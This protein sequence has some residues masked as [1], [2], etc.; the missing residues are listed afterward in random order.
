MQ[1]IC[2]KDGNE[3]AGNYNGLFNVYGSV[4]RNNILVLVYNYV[5]EYT[6]LLDK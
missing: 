3:Q 2:E 5:P 6:G 4:Q 1:V